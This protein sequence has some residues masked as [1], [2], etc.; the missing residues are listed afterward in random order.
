MSVKY[1]FEGKV[2]LIT[3]S[4][5]GIGAS[6]AILF[7]KS[8][9]SVVVTGRNAKNVSEVAKKCREVSHDKSKALE[10]VADLIKEEDLKRLVDITIKTYGKIDILVNNAGIGFW[11]DIK[12]ED[13]Y[14]KYRK[15]LELNLNSVVLL[16]HL[17]VSHLEKTKG[18]IINISSIASL[19]PVIARD[20]FEFMKIN[21][22]FFLT[23][24]NYSRPTMWPK[25][26]WIC[27]PDVWP[28]NSVQKE[29]E[30]MLS[31]N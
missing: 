20:Q 17:C 7:A 9:A 26:E 10:V 23:R 6:T 29:F 18:N 27:S 12:D 2:A 4:S 19:R 13:Y 28:Q 21:L 16:T 30:S 8:G 31:S 11:A 14:E 15:V 22:V 3:G 25:Q 1:D 5:S 24:Q